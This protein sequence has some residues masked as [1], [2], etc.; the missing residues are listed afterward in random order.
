MKALFK[1]FHKIEFSKQLSQN[2][3]SVTS[4]TFS[5]ACKTNSQ[6]MALTVVPDLTP[7]SDVTV[8]HL[9][10]PAAAVQRS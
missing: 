5:V 7:W 3:P 9:H 4:P 6:P 8:S 1:N 10:T 2:K